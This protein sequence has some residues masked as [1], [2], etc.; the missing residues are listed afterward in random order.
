MANHDADINLRVDLTPG[1]VTST[2]RDLRQQI[3]GILKSN[4]G[5]T[6]N[7]EFKQILDNM[8]RVSGRAKDIIKSMA[9]MEVVRENPV[10]V[11]MGKQLDSLLGKQR[12]LTEENRKSSIELASRQARVDAVKREHPKTYART[13]EYKEQTA[14]VQELE[15]S[16]EQNQNELTKTENAIKQ[17]KEQLEAMKQ[18]GKDV[19]DETGTEEYKKL[20][21]RL[22]ALIQAM[23]TYIMQAQRT[24]SET[25]FSPELSKTVDS[26]TDKLSTAKQSF[27]DLWQTSK[28]ISEQF[29]TA[30]N[31]ITPS[32]K[33]V[34]SEIQQI[35]LRMRLLPLSV[36]ESTIKM[37][38]RWADMTGNMQNKWD[39][40]IDNIMG[41][42]EKAGSK[43]G[44]FAD[45]WQNVIDSVYSSANKGTLYEDFANKMA[46]GLPRVANSIGQFISKPLEFVDKAA[47]F[48]LNGITKLATSGANAISAGF[49]GALR[50]VGDGIGN[51][52]YK[53]AQ[54]AVALGQFAGSK[55]SGGLKTIGAHALNAAKNLAKMG[56]NAAKAAGRGIINGFKRLAS[57]ITKTNKASSNANGTF[58]RGFLFILRYALGIRSI[59]F[60]FRRLRKALG[61]GF[62]NLARYSGGFNSVVSDFISALTRLKNTFATAFAPIVNVVLPIITTFINAMSEAVTRVGMLIAALTGQTTFI[63]AKAV[64]QDYAASLDKAAGSADKAKK[65]AE[66]YQRTISGFDDVEILKEP[67]DDSS[68]GS[69][70]PGGGGG[71]GG[72]DP[73]D[74]FETVGLPAGY[75]DL[76]Q[77]IKDSWANADFTDLGALLG[78]K[79]ADALYNIPWD[80]IQQYAGK[81]GKSFATFINGLLSVE[82]LARAIGYTIGQ[83]LNT[84]FILANGFVSNLNWEQVG[85][86]FADVMNEGIKTIKW[87]LIVDTLAKTANGI[88]N[89][90]N[91]WATEFDFGALGTAISNTVRDTLANL[92]W[93]NIKAA[94][95]NL[96]AGL[97]EFVNNLIK[98]STFSSIGTTIAEAINTAI[99]GIK[100]FA[101]NTDWPNLGHSIA[102]GLSSFFTKLNLKD[103]GFTLGTFAN[104]LLDA[105]TTAVTDPSIDWKS[106]GNKIIEGIREFFDTFE[107]SKVAGLLFALMDVGAAILEGML[108]GIIDWLKNNPIANWIKEHIFTPFINGIKSIF[109]I[110]SPSKEMKPLGENIILGLF[111]GILDWITKNPFSTWINNHILK[112][113]KKAWEDLGGISGIIDNV[114]EIGVNLTNKFG[115]VAEWFSGL[116]EDITYASTKIKTFLSRADWGTVTK[117][118]GGLKKGVTHASTKIKT[119]L[120]RSDWGTVKKWWSNLGDKITGIKSKKINTVLSRANWGTVQSWWDNLKDK[121]TNI[122]SKTIHT[123][124]SRSNWETVQKWFNGLGAKYTDASTTLKVKLKSVWDSIV[125]WF[126]KTFSGNART[127]PVVTMLVKYKNK[128]KPNANDRKDTNPYDAEGAAYYGYG[129]TRHKIAQYASGGAPTHGTTFVA[130]EAGAEVVGHIHGRT[131]VL[132]QSQM[133]AVMYSSVLAAVSPVIGYM[134]ECTNAIITNIGSELNY[135]KFMS[136]QLYDINLLS[137]S[138]S[139]NVGNIVTGK[140]VPNNFNST[141]INNLNQTLDK[142]STMLYDTRS[143]AVTRDELV[144]VL[145]TMFTRYMNFSCYIGDEDIA[146][147]A[148]N[149]NA[150]LEMRFNPVAR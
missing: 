109:G 112:P 25:I 13:N 70:S 9:K 43:I 46:S 99:A 125:Q 26:V 19:F 124:L 113:I 120:S 72:I 71:G 89:A 29:K 142:L 83:A 88:F 132:N 105:V 76:A 147:H 126:N 118:F 138:L 10:Y 146:R 65:S 3:D 97:A 30:F 40:T 129:Y 100:S 5:K 150:R 7:K 47:G 101:I 110:A 135:L 57:A 16:L 106:V 17:V 35:P 4:S 42:A 137:N 148:N 24:R 62:G 49:P 149:G 31:G 139:T 59:Y 20:E 67:D 121:V 11:K 92:K 145:T 93:D 1:D 15:K 130:G 22:T 63:R 68:G 82:E 54:G 58:K 91:T 53:A 56:A 33:R 87:D 143:N 107:V 48:A 133:A 102:A 117:W 39:S 128:N 94:V 140:V 131:E 52:S 122:K 144:S 64:Q 115:T 134:K 18:A 21:A 77:M 50:S 141:D 136:G 73:A 23:Q 66:E 6:L 55:I 127:S 98:P 119:I 32:I 108:E 79:I 114:V 90:L 103:A 34:G 37:Q 8:E 96:G 36:Q 28:P 95:S 2:A 86:F 69:G 116:G 51:I 12:E 85:K 60:L 44:T 74:M 27:T 111:Q 80:T 104:G 78:Q 75:Y 41:G 61:E 84:L 123:V 45:N 14:A 81:F 38:G